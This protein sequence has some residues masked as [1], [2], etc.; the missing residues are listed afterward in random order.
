MDNYSD[1]LDN[2]RSNSMVR[3]PKEVSSWTTSSAEDRLKAFSPQA[4][5]VWDYCSVFIHPSPTYMSLHEGA[6]KVLDYVI[7]QA[8]TYTLTT[9][10]IILD[11][12]AVFNDR[13]TKLL[14]TLAEQ[15]LI[16]KLPINLARFGKL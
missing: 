6:P 16:D 9:R 13:E 12:C 14:N 7:G 15:L 1:Y 3:I 8:N 10:H 11:N 5:T 4:A 2:L